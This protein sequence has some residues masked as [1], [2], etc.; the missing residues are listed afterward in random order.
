M[1]AKTEDPFS[2]FF[3]H[4]HTHEQSL[5]F[6]TKIR[7]LIVWAFFH[8]VL[9]KMARDGNFRSFSFS[10]NRVLCSSKR[11]L[12][13]SKTPIKWV[14]KWAS[15][16][17]WLKGKSSATA[18][19]FWPICVFVFYSKRKL[20]PKHNLEIYLLIFRLGTLSKR[21]VLLAG[22]CYQLTWRATSFHSVNVTDQSGPEN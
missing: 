16:L 9:S 19:Q 14:A 20:S 3:Q 5:I 17:C 21:E 15:S 13:C 2:I 12:V 1:K 22:K 6:S 8:D 18:N 7:K 11:K 10:L 4:T